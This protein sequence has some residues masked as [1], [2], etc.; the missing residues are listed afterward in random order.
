M[1]PTFSKVILIMLVVALPLLGMMAPDTALLKEYKI[2]LVLIYNFIKFT[3]W[4][5]DRNESEVL[6]LGIVGD[7]DVYGV[8][9]LLNNK[10]AQNKKIKILRIT[11]KDLKAEKPEFAKSVDI[12]FVSRKRKKGI[13][14]ARL[15][16]LIKG[17]SVLVIGETIGFLDKG[18]II[19]F[20]K[21]DN[22]VSFEINLDAAKN[23]NLQIKTTV[24]KLAKKII[25]K[26]IS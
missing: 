4:P 2:K 19:N 10:P 20:M 17:R 18:G 3:D 8:L 7:D 25:P 23:A 5:A 13:D 16:E 15:L 12:L 9:K 22:H 26:K 1:R 14:S 21:D 11:G 24:L 6:T